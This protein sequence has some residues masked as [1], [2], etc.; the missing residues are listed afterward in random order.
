MSTHLPFWHRSY[1]CNRFEMSTRSN[2]MHRAANCILKCNMIPN[3]RTAPAVVDSNRKTSLI[4]TWNS[5]NTSSQIVANSPKIS[6]WWRYRW[7]NFNSALELLVLI[8]LTCNRFY[9]RNT[10]HWWSCCA[11]F[12]CFSLQHFRSF[13]IINQIFYFQKIK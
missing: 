1:D 9:W 13:P 6:C 8:G 10:W 7:Q 4:I 3:D 11:F 12:I 5:F 2:I